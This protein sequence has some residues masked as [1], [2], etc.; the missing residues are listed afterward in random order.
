MTQN[1]YKERILN[2]KNL[3]KEVWATD[4]K[5]INELKIN[6]ILLN[7]NSNIIITPHLNIVD[8]SNK[9]FAW[10][11]C[12]FGGN[13]YLKGALVSAFSLKTCY[14]KVLMYTKDVV[15]DQD[16]EKEIDLIFNKKVEVE[17]LQFPCKQ[18]RTKK[19]NEIYGKW[20]DKSFTKWNFMRLTEYD[21]VIYADS[22]YI[23]KDCEET[24]FPDTL[25]ELNAPAGTFSSAWSSRFTKKSGGINIDMYPE[26]H[27]EIIPAETIVSAIKMEGSVAVIGAMILIEPNIKHFNLFIEY[28][29]NNLP[30]GF[31]GCNSGF[32][33]QS[34]SLFYS[35]I[36]KL[37]WTFIHQRFNFIPWKKNWLPSKE[38]VCG[39]HYFNIIKPWDYC[40]IPKEFEDL[41]VYF[42][43]VS[44]LK[45][46]KHIYQFLQTK[47][48]KELV[49]IYIKD[50]NEE[51]NYIKD[52]K[53]I[54]KVLSS[55]F[56][57]DKIEKF[58]NE[59]ENDYLKEYF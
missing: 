54:L 59:K 35:E 20:I 41:Q 30:Y 43:A 4:D 2:I 26:T 11:W 18:M 7:E 37:D 14:D 36:L 15:F 8:K 27:T 19:Q 47:N 25:F 17:Y 34:L 1:L 39:Y 38:S 33:E 42:D 29:S 56:T 55:C 40:E 48:I 46:Y 24:S 10:V 9:K 21:K 49:N 32:D 13:R 58:L 52:K 6:N 31:T 16:L 12:V 44:S 22:D 57:K 5:T 23:F 50:Y 28:I 53:D 51:K 3:N 45:K